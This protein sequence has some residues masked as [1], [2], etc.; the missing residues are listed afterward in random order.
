MADRSDREA[1]RT[2]AGVPPFAEL[3]TFKGDPFTVGPREALNLSATFAIPGSRVQDF[4]AAMGAKDSQWQPLPIPPGVKKRISFRFAGLTMESP[5]GFFRCRT[6]GDNVLYAK[7]T[8]SCLNPRAWVML[9]KDPPSW[10]I[11]EVPLSSIDLYSDIILSVY[12]L[13]S[14]TISVGIASGY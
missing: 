8:A 6:A 12:D 13:D 14:K 2:Q 11:K 7:D 9:R 10:E 1:L 3:V 5:R 4:E